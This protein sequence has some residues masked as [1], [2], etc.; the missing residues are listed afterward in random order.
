MKHNIIKRLLSAI[1]SLGMIASSAS[2]VSALD[3][4]I[5]TQSS[6]SRSAQAEAVAATEAD[7]DSDLI[8]LAN[9]LAN[10][11]HTSY[12]SA[13][14][15]ILN[16]KNQ[17]MSLDYNLWAG[18]NN[19]NVNRLTNTK[20][21]S[22]IE[23]TMDVFV[24]TDD[25]ETYYSSKS[26]HSAAMNIYRYGYYYYENRIEGQVF[27][28]E[29]QTLKSI[30]V[31]HLKPSSSNAIGNKSTSNNEYSYTITGSDPYVI[32]ND[33]YITASEYDYVELTVKATQASATSQLFI[34]AGSATD[35]T[36]TQSYTF[37][38]ATDGEYH[39]YYIPLSKIPDYTGTLK[40][41]RFDINGATNSKVYI[42]SIKVIK[43]I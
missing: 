6:Q 20:G 23:N 43:A 7:K 5:A 33:L 19:M 36:S 3:S 25:G 38:M 29:I 35:Y 21:A 11:T 32:Y 37:A 13:Y 12:T 41:L 14:R 22:Y 24:K 10:G 9:S 30:S 28:P 15:D 8:E 4:A 1:L 18:S 17:T 31:N 42:K 27:I 2:Y 16:I 26:T 40:G 39:T 34:W